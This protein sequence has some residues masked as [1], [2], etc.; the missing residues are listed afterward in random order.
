MLLSPEIAL[1]DNFKV[2]VL[3]DQAFQQ[4]LVLVIIDEAHV[5][6]EWGQHW[7]KL[8]SQVGLL[9]DLIDKSVPWLSCS[10]TLNPVILAEVIDLCRFNP[11]FHI[12]YS[13]IDQPNITSKIRSIQYPILIF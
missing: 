13:L 3:Q 8:Y 5:I 9:R 11:D 12:Q 4:R 1:L 7:R 6:S 2:K 10:A